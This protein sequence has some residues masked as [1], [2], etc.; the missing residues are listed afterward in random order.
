MALL[1]DGKS[2][3]SFHML[4]VLP[5]TAGRCTGHPGALSTNGSRDTLRQSIDT[6]THHLSPNSCNG[7]GS[8]N[9]DPIG[10]CIEGFREG[11]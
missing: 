5:R 1:K 9:E 6:I 8:P 10:G 7:R 3:F 2:L 4:R 11:R